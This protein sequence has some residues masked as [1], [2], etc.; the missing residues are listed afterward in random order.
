[1]NT[2]LGYAEE[3]VFSKS[4]I[5]KKQLEEAINQFTSENFLCSLTL[6]GAAEEIFAGLLRAQDKKPV[7]EASYS[8]I[9]R[10]RENL[11]VNVMENKRKKEVFRDW[12]HAKNR[13]KHHDKS[14]DYNI[15]FNPCDEAYWMIK[16]ALTNSGMLNVSISN[17][18]DFEN[19]IIINVC[20]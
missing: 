9:E 1:V 20:L 6:A 16:R 3:I 8:A 2:T 17:E 4:D 19:W 10:L 15:T 5:A 12:N 13:S 7:I 14:E 18:S 11:K